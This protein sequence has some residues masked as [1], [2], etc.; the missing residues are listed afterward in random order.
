M[1]LRTII[2]SPS[3]VAEY[4]STPESIGLNTGR[5]TQFSR[6]ARPSVKNRSFLPLLLRLETPKTTTAVLKGTQNP[7]KT[8]D[9]L[10]KPVSISECGFSACLASVGLHV[11]HES[12]CGSGRS[13]EVT[14]PV[15]ATVA[16]GEATDAS[17]WRKIE[18]GGGKE[19]PARRAAPKREG[20]GSRSVPSPPSRVVTPSANIAGSGSMGENGGWAARTGRARWRLW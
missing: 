8:P 5:L 6:S 7:G 20:E 3:R 13:L 2:G 14:R 17:G 18:G 15:V 11:E 12:I 10:K 1:R 9:P 19:S 4:A 16:T